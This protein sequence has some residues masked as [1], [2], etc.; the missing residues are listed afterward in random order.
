MV[1]MVEKVEFVCDS[2]QPKQRPSKYIYIAMKRVN[3]HQKDVNMSSYDTRSIVGFKER[4]CKRTCLFRLVAS[5]EKPSR[6]RLSL[7]PFPAMKG[8]SDAGYVLSTNSSLHAGS[9]VAPFR[10]KASKFAGKGRKKD[11]RGGTFGSIPLK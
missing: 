3:N 8:S 2:T 6:D 10:S 1:T 4:T 11:C 7:R 5:D 9:L